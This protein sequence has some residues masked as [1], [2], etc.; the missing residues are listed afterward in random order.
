MIEVERGRL[1]DHDDTVFG[2]DAKPCPL[3]GVEVRDEAHPDGVQRRQRAQP[4]GRSKAAEARW[5]MERLS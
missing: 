2:M 5:F 3:S 1:E 4:K